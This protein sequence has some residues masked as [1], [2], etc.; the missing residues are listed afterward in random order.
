VL[1]TISSLDSVR[2]SAVH[3][4]PA[5]DTE[6]DPYSTERPSRR[7]Q[8]VAL[9]QPLN[10][11]IQVGS[12]CF[13]TAGVCDVKVLGVDLALRRASTWWSVS[14]SALGTRE[15]ISMC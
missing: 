7:T 8:D 1:A 12:Q 4:S 5:L 9:K 3:R 13:R 2:P 10:N 6:D 15:P 11:P 14:L